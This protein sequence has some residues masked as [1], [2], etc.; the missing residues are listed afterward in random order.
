MKTVK[1]FETFEEMKSCEQKTADSIA[2]LK[3]HK[4]FEKVI[5]EINAAKVF[6]DNYGSITNAVG[7]LKILIFTLFIF[8]IIYYAIY[9]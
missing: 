4:D 9:R 5:M 7:N 2:T 8:N 6:Q 1:K 3:K